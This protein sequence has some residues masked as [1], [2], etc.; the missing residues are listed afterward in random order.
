[1]RSAL[2]YYALLTSFCT[3]SLKGQEINK[4]L[5]LS[6]ENTKIEFR[7]KHFGVI[8]VSGTFKIFQGQ[9]TVVNNIVTV[10]RVNLNVNSLTTNNKSRD[11][12]L[13]NKEFLNPEAYPTIWVDFQNNTNPAIIQ[14]HIKIKGHTNTIPIRYQILDKN[15]DTKTIEATCEISREKFQLDL[16]SMDDL[17]SDKVE[18]AVFVTLKV[19]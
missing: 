16:G 6:P 3:Y 5:I 13:K 15:L 14:S 19:K 17:V 10:A 1:M 12:S 9:L 8:N 11:K 2:L 4:T 18:V 7:A